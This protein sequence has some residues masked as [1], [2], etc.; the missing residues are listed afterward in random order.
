MSPPE[1]PS[2]ATDPTAGD[3]ARRRGRLGRAPLPAGSRL[4]RRTPPGTRA[5]ASR[6]SSSG[7]REARARP[8]PST[9]SPGHANSGPFKPIATSVPGMLLGPHLPKLARQAKDLAIIRSMSS[10]EGDHGRATYYLRTGYLP[11]GPIRYPTLGSL[12]ANEFDDESAELPGFVS[13]SPV[14]AINA[15]AFS[16]GFLGPKCA[17]LNVGERNLAGGPDAGNSSL[18]VEDLDIPRGIGRP[19]ADERLELMLTLGNDFLANRPGVP[20]FSH[21]SAYRRAVKMMRSSAAKAF[22]LDEEPAAV[23]DAYGRNPFGQG[24]LLARRLVERGVPFVEVTLSSVDGNNGLGWDTHA[25]N[26]ETVEKLS[27]VLDAG[28]STLM[29]DLRSRGLLDSTLDRLDGRVRPDAQDQRVGRPRPFPQRLVDRTR[30]RRDPRR[31]DDRRHRGRR[32]RDQGPARPGPRPARDRRSRAWGSTRPSRT[33]SRTAGRSGSSTRR[34]TRSRNFS[35]D[36][37]AAFLVLAL[38]RRAVARARAG[39]RPRAAAARHLI[40]LAE[41]RPIFVRLRVT[42]GGRPFEASWIDS[43]R[44]IH[45]SLDRNGDGTLTT[46]EA[47]PKI[48]DGA[49]AAGD[50]RGRGARSWRAGRPPERRQGLDRRAGRGPPSDPGSV[51]APGR[52]AG[53]RPHRC[54]LRSARPRQGRRAHAGPSWRRSPD[55][56]GRSTST[57]TK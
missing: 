12:V 1:P 38:A 48:V 55:R 10:K 35:D 36:G 21:Q 51:P 50:G 49:R 43:I 19:R 30:R 39:R 24:C 2:S 32:R 8:T 57:I 33:P 20:S 34:P 40:F 46:K 29:T 23:Q 56:C 9:P 5:A 11:Q 27:G 41:Q 22:D 26:F 45:A 54:A 18:R 6:A 17:P 42:S 47:D 52:A 25:Q 15:A 7:C 3:A 37:R 53:G 14:R 44:A 28:W 16:S 13:I 4:W 31:A